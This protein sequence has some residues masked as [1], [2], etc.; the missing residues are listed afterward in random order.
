MSTTP[1][2]PADQPPADPTAP[3]AVVAEGTGF[4]R[5]VGFLGLF[6]AVLGAV[7]IITTRAVGPRWVSEGYGFVSAG[8]GLALML[9][10]AISDG[11]QE[12]R[13]MYGGLAALMLVLAV[14][15]GLVPGPFG[16]P[17]KAVGYYL[18][19][20]GFGAGFVALLFAVP[21]V[22]HETS[23]VLRGMVLNGLLFVG[24]A[25]CAAV[26]VVGA[27]A[28]DFL[29]VP[30][31]PLALLGL[32]YLCT[33]LSYTDT[34]TGVG[35]SVAVGIGA[36]G[37]LVAF[38]A[39]ARTVFPTLL[40]DGPGVLRKPDQTLD[41]W[42]AVG[43]LLVVAV[44]AGVAAL[45]AR[46]RLALWA[47]VAL[48]GGALVSVGVFAVA[49]FA[50]TAMHPPKPFLVPGGLIL[51]LLGLLY[52]G[53]G[54]GTSSDNQLATLTRRELGWY[55]VSPIGLL[56]LGGIAVAQWIG[57]H[58]FVDL[59]EARS[60]GGRGALPEPIVRFYIVALFPI[61]ALTLQVPA[62]TM[63]LLAE[64]KR[65]GSMEVLLT[66]PVSEWAVVL[67]KFAATWLFFIVSWLPMGLYLLVLRAEG[68]A[69]FDMRPLLGFY[70]ALA[71][72]G[73]AF[74]ALG[75][76]VSALTDNQIV[77]AVLTFI[78]MVV[79]LLCYMLKDRPL[80]LGQSVQLLLA[81]LSYIDLWSESL[82]GQ[83]PLRDVLL[84]LSLAG[85]LLFVTIKVLEIRRWR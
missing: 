49:S 23:P 66:A 78:G 77:A 8:L 53:V 80:G 72:T 15:F 82:K 26:P 6:L 40:F 33:Y 39:L 25:L 13:R 35:R 59:L 74:V 73:A 19:P 12:V 85:F 1:F 37:A 14:A 84:W 55:F 50:T 48:G 83:L 5:V 61:F 21:F 70:L 4:T 76:L 16:G 38:Y 31:L 63:R 18:L 75:L 64:E 28:P 44:L 62:L 10:H 67:S 42:A 46:S 81:K 69:P 51:G 43:R 56:V 11:E 54:L 41:K 30:G 58:Q 52:L 68:G 79:L 60:A 24:A 22:R 17:G 9:F 27:F 71:A 3:S 57:Y 65:T 34:D 45:A 2:A 29:A 7:V 36:F 32:G 20:W 47:K